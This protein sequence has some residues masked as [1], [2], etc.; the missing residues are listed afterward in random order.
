MIFNGIE[1]ISFGVSFSKNLCWY[2]TFFF[3]ILVHLHVNRL[4]VLF[5]INKT[6]WVFFYNN[7]IASLSL[8][9]PCISISLRQKMRAK[10]LSDIN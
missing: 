8:S 5:K 9:I 2:P 7:E 4:F 1:T 10:Y 3:I 6:M